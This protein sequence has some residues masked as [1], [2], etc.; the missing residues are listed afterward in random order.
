MFDGAA[1]DALVCIGLSLGLCR[2]RMVVSAIGVHHNVMRQVL[3]AAAF[4]P[5]RNPI[6]HACTERR[7]YAEGSGE[8]GRSKGC[9]LCLAV[10]LRVWLDAS[11]RLRSDAKMLCFVPLMLCFVPLGSAPLLLPVLGCVL[12]AMPDVPD[13]EANLSKEEL[14]A[15]EAK[16]AEKREVCGRGGREWVGGSCFGGGDTEGE[17]AGM[18][19]EEV[20]E[21]V[22]VCGGR[23]PSVMAGTCPDSPPPRRLLTP[24]CVVL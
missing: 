2:E 7:G 23:R 10:S 20:Q 9:D 3:D 13:G 8:C 15:L 24:F 21:V 16:R 4:V 22:G 12:N 1:R 5:V 11:V 18:Q 6:G 14:E 19:N 17:S